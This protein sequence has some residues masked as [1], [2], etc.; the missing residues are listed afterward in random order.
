MKESP[1]R[2]SSSR[3]TTSKSNSLLLPPGLAHDWQVEMQG[4]DRGRHK[5]PA[6]CKQWQ[7]GPG[8][9]VIRSKWERLEAA[10]NLTLCS[11]AELKPIYFDYRMYWISH[12]CGFKISV[13]LGHR[14]F[15]FVKSC[16][17]YP[18]P[19]LILFCFV[20]LFWLL[21]I[22]DLSSSTKDW[23]W[24]PYIGRAKS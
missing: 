6:L 21:S 15:Y 8:R 22:Q 4:W 16:L 7:I 3:E 10:F 14:G 12:V 11:L 24:A 18:L 23:T 20:F 19:W 5:W 1:S 9:E 17:F 13:D 2:F